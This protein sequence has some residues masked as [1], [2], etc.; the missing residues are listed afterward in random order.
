MLS[1]VEMQEGD[2]DK[3]EGSSRRLPDEEG[4]D[5]NEEL[6]SELQ[7]LRKRSAKSYEVSTVGFFA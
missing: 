6:W 2:E 7:S 3:G 5:L 4:K 1:M